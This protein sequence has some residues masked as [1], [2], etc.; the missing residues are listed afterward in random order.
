MIISGTEY[1][2]LV[3]SDADRDG[4]SWECYCNFEG[5]EKLVLE[6]FRNDAKE[7]FEVS[8][9]VS[10]LPLELYEYVIATAREKLGVI[11]P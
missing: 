10:E 11:K 5:E 9:F 4:L 6:V 8:P 2:F 7:C 3:A 1:T